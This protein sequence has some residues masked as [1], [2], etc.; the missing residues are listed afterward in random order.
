MKKKLRYDL[1]RTYLKLNIGLVILLCITGLI[2]NVS[3]AFIPTLQGFVVD[4]LKENKPFDY[5]LRLGFIYLG[6]V[7]FVQINRFL[8]RLF[9]RKMSN[10]ITLQMRTKAFSNLLLYDI[11][12]FDTKSYGDIMNRQLLD[13]RDSSESIETVIAE[14]FDSGVLLISY[15]VFMAIHSLWLASVCMIFPVLVILISVLFGPKIRRYTKEYKQIYSDT[16][17]ENIIVLQNEIYYRGFGINKNYYASYEKSINSLERKATRN[18]IFRTSF[19]PLY[20]GIAAFGYVFAFYFGGQK[21]IEGTWKIGTLLAFV[22]SFTFARKKAGFVGRIINNIQNGF[23]AWSRCKG[24]MIEPIEL[25]EL[26]ANEDANIVVSDLSFGYDE[27]FRIKN[28]SFAAKKGDIIGVCGKIRSG[29]TTLAGALSG[30]YDY[31]GSIK[32]C[33]LELKDVKNYKIK[34]FIHYAPGKV[35]IFND[36]LKYNVTF[37]GEGDFNTAVDSA[38]LNEDIYGFK[39]KEEEV[40]S[41]SLLNISGG[42]QRRLQIARS[43][44]GNPKLIILDDPFN[45]IGIDMSI[46]IIN[47]FKKHYKDSI[48]IIINNQYET[49]KMFDKILY[50]KNNTSVFSTYDN[51][52]LDKEFKSLVVGGD[53]CE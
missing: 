20:L 33:G 25:N 30:I 5:V 51:L 53:S 47:N 7:L 19:E 2:F 1:I 16:K 14:I 28:V 41:H 46:D 23:V 42:Q 45:A 13:I 3:V 36:T 21:V 18:S 37:A 35:E 26:E 50:L 10:K 27:K 4:S 29:K 43:L 32:L 49:L 6:F 52:L 39:N 44:Y 24:Y 11:K 34:N 9:R 8:K 40:L 31:D 48:F 17:E 22:G 12:T 15:F 38:C